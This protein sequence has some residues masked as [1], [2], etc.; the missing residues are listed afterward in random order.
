ML[1][2][3]L[4]VPALL[5]AV[6][7]APALAAS[8]PKATGSG[9]LILD[10]T[11]R[12]FAFTAQADENGDVKGMG[13]IQNRSRGNHVKFQ[14]T[15]LRVEANVATMSGFVTLTTDEDFDVGGPVWFRAIDNGE[16]GQEPA[17]EMTLVGLWPLG[18]AAPTCD[19]D[20][21][22]ILGTQAVLDGGNIQVRGAGE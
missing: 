3:R 15:C 5:L 1:R 9:H 14:I 10:L 13:N 19:F 22:F 12:T 2:S 20:E 8:G 7:A 17:D 11:R 21:P 4:L 6:T 16:G 18:T